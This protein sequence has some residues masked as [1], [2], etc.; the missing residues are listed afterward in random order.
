MYTANCIESRVRSRL[1]VIFSVFRIIAILSIFLCSIESYSQPNKRTNFWYFADSCGLDFN[2]GMPVEDFSGLSYTQGF[3]VTGSVM[4][5]TN[6]NLLFYSNGRQI[7]NKEHELMNNGYVGPPYDPG[8]QSSIAFPQPGSDSIYYIFTSRYI[9][10]Q[11]PMFYYIVDMSQNNG[12]GE[13]TDIVYLPSYCD[14]TEKL[15]AV[16]QNNKTDLWVVTR[17]FR[18]KRYASFQVT[19]EGV[20]NNPVFSPAPEE[21]FS[22]GWDYA[23]IMKV[24]YDKKYMVSCFPGA[25]ASRAKVEVCKIDIQ[26][27][28]ITHLYSFK[29]RELVYASPPYRTYSCEFSPDSKYMYLSGV[30]FTDSITHV[31]QFDM[32]YI[33]DSTA[34]EQSITQIGVGQGNSLQ[35]AP[36][37]KIYCFGIDPYLAWFYPEN[38]YVGIIHNPEK[39]AIACNYEANAFLIDYGTVRYGT[40]NLVTDFLFRFD[41]EGICESDTFTFDPWFFP[42]PTYIEWNFGDVL[43]GANNTSTIPH[44]THK[45]TDGG[46]YEVSVHVEYPNGRIEETSRVVEVVYAPEPDLGTDTTFCSTSGITLDA[47]CGDHFYLWSTGAFGTSQITVSD[48]GWYWVRVENNAGCFETDSIHLSAYPPAFVDTTSLVV[49]PT[50]CGGS[51]GAITGLA[52]SG[53]PP[54]SYIWTNDIGDTISSNLDLFHLAVGNYTLHVTDGN[55]CNSLIGPYTIHDAGDVLIDDVTYSSEYCDQQNGTITV[56]ATS[57]LTEMLFYS[58]DNGTTYYNNQGNFT[59]LPAGSYAVRVKDSTDC[60]DVYIYNPIIIENIPGPQLDNVVVTPSVTGQNN[61][62][63]EI[64]ASG[65][66]DTLYYSNDNGSSY[67]INNGWFSNL[68]AGFYNCIVMD[69]NGCDTT[70]IVEV[71]EETILRLQAIA[72]D[73]EACPGNAAFVPLIVT[74]FQDV[75]TFRTNL[76]YNNTLL[77]CQGYANANAQLEDSLEVIVFPAEGRIELSWS[78]TSVTLPQQSILTDLVFSST[79]P[80]INQIEWDG[81]QGSSY[82]LNSLGDD[83]PVDYYMGNVKIYNEVSVALDPSL[84]ACEG[85]DIT[86]MPQLLSS[87]GE[88]SYLWTY[89]NGDTSLQQIQYLNNIQGGSSGTYYLSV[90]DTAQCN[91]E[92]ALDLVVYSNPVPAFSGQDTITTEVPVEIDAGANHATYS[93]TTGENSQFIT[94]VHEGWYGVLIESLQG[95]YGED[96]IYVLFTTPPPMEPQDNLI[97]VP[98]A[99]SPNKDGLNDEFKAITTSNQISSFRMYIYNRWGEQIFESSDISRGWDGEYKG[100]PSPAGAYVYKIDYMLGSLAEIRTM[101]GVVVLVR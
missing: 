79:I 36:D 38:N 96:S 29:L 95:C 35:L 1:V 49:I 77:D 69:E 71:T 25:G 91:L 81:Q 26:S 64:I 4:S 10:E 19:T 51:M 6:G 13:V 55:G 78:S 22:S 75:A 54:F 72:G 45:F 98:N 59:E 18:D 15:T 24:S 32:Q 20:N 63:I 99:F 23:G 47:E 31:F 16:Y 21:N 92:A 8:T 7:W 93:W 30:I 11:F 2:S 12:L 83:I 80:G 27:G 57:G 66:G 76:L 62:A 44:A 85:D 67:Q 14:A 3:G 70:F 73:D 33:E 61:G 58:L 17:S 52:F 48:T 84:E 34:F 56:T 101:S 68:S 86:I 94:A 9:D 37:G 5:D 41:F 53:I 50:T 90:T 87:N 60:Q 74:N 82:F 42:E 39:R 100:Q 88:V 46:S 43:S 40:V 97:F 28:S 65:S 89:P